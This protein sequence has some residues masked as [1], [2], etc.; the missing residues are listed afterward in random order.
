MT[1]R[2][3][4]RTTD[5]RSRSVAL[6]KEEMQCLPLCFNDPLGF[7]SVKILLTFDLSTHHLIRLQADSSPVLVILRLPLAGLVSQ[8]KRT[9]VCVGADHHLCL[10]LGCRLQVQCAH[11]FL[12]VC[13]VLLIEQLTPETNNIHQ[14]TPSVRTALNSYSNASS[15]SQH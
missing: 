2:R 4:S 1:S 10:S 6:H 9:E 8:H 13:R 15:H 5:V 14:N 3:S 12:L 11:T 7:R